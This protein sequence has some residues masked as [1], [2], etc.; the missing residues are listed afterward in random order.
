[1]AKTFTITT[2]APDTIKTDARGH[3]EAVYTVTNTT[4]RPVRGMA[5]AA[6]LDSTKQE[7]LQIT[8]EAD[9]DFAAGSTQQFV[10]TFDAPV[11]A[12]K[13]AG[14]GGSATPAADTATTDKYG[15]R[16][17][18]ASATN[19]DEDFT[20]GQTIRVE[21]PKAEAPKET[22]P[23]PKWIFIP[24][25]I[26][27]L[28][29]IGL[30]LWLVLRGGKPEPVVFVVPDVAGVAQADAQAR[31]ETECE[32]GTGC[33]VVTVGPVADNTVAKGNAIGTDPVA[34]TEVE[35]GSPVTL[36]ISSGPEVNPVETF[37]LPAVANVAE[38]AAKSSLEKG[39]KKQEGC[40][41]VEVSSVTDAKAPSGMAIRTEPET[42]SEVE[43]GSKVKL[44]VSK[45]PEKV[46]IQN[47]ANQ[48]SDGAMDTLEKSCSPAPCL[49]VEVNRIP[50]NKVQLGRVIRTQPVA[51]SV[52]NAGS[53]VTLFVSGGTDE[54]TIP[55]VRNKTIAEARLAL[56]T[57]C[58]PA[59]CLQVTQNNLNDDLVEAGRVIGTNPPN[60]KA[61]KIGS[62]IVLNVSTGKEL[63]LVGTYT[64]LTEAAARQRIVADGFT[65]GPVKRV[66]MLFISPQVTA[67]SPA[68]GSK[69]PKGSQISLTIIGGK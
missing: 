25:A 63:K 52:V 54:V 10:V 20:E 29:V 47:V 58:K 12:P 57:A 32:A 42:D 4:S 39:C 24:I 67:Q 50:D 7:W 27:V 28:L 3:A 46:T 14:T 61:V 37:K 31:L 44:F 23:F 45:G 17:I 51:G 40:V 62:A 30:V 18:V 64:K 5:K 69:K 26:V 60:G 53:K 2:T 11:A 9:R 34:G 6:A 43:V 35:V 33:L 8:G 22:K 21:M 1:M 13:P 55:L 59:P 38:A 15:F 16:L 48:T 49:D 36:I 66:P 56:I 68:A 19:P 65:V 41:Q